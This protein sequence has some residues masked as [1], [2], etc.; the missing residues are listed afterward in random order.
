MALVQLLQLSGKV[1]G[2]TKT[3]SSVTSFPRKLQLTAD[4]CIVIA[5]M[6]KFGANL[7][8]ESQDFKFF[9]LDI[10]HFFKVLSQ[11]SVSNRFREPMFKKASLLVFPTIYNYK[12]YTNS[13][14]SKLFNWEHLMVSVWIFPY[15]YYS[16]LLLLLLF[17]ACTYVYNC[18]INLMCILDD[19]IFKSSPP[20][21]SAAT[22]NFLIP[23][24]K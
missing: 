22:G 16:W 5:R 12:V 4:F 18:Y 10:C 14:M 21:F 6:G 11:N 23:H 15:F 19:S 20:L 8:W 7:K 9:L 1:T 13:Q 24:E 17:F 3:R 2:R